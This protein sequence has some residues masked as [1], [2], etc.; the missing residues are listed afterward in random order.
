M[1]KI[2]E[3]IKNF[4]IKIKDIIVDFCVNYFPKG[5]PK[6][7]LFPL[8]LMLLIE[9]I[10]TTMIGA[11]GGYLLVDIG[12]AKDV[13]DAGTY[14]GWLTS[15]FH[16][17]QFLSSFVIGALSDNIG[18]RPMLLFG[19]FG[20]ALTNILFG[21]SFN[22]YYAIAMRFINGLINGNIGV[23]KTYMGEVS[24]PENR[25]KTFS[26]VGLTWA[27]GSVVGNFL[28]GILYDPC[29]K[30][31]SVF[32]TSGLFK[33]FPA[34]L[35]QGSVGIVGFIVLI[36]AYFYLPENI[37][38]GKLDESVKVNKC[39]SILE[40]IKMVFV[41]M[42]RFFNRKNKWSLF[43]TFEYF[44]L[45]FCH[46]TFLT[47]YPLLII[48]SVGNGGFGLTTNEVG[49]FSAIAFTGSIVTLSFFYNPLVRLFGMR[50]TFSITAYITAC[51]YGL[52]PALE[53]LND[54]SDGVKWTC[55]ALLAFGWNLANQCTFSAIM[56]LIVN[57]CEASYMGSANGIAQMVVSLGRILGPILLSPLLSWSLDNGLSYP[58]NQY[59][60][61]YILLV[62]A[63]INASLMFITPERI[64][65]PPVSKT[66]DEEEMQ[67]EIAEEKELLPSENETS[68]LVGNEEK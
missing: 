65:R 35:P 40:S 38:P 43:C 14:T 3:A 45:G 19:T 54:S 31:P 44:L 15:S 42:Y 51:F 63:C 47:L 48:A 5:F 68:S 28:G 58:F 41:K 36:L 50:K 64:E 11:Y 33:Q 18:R 2:L 12:M 62:I 67:T 4:F 46:T 27:V 9:G 1:A 60:P 7:K 59:L 49:Y 26:F 37:V 23:V 32:G 61:F 13:D 52:Y 6:R 16:I 22:F 8:L 20:I 56:T 39:K 17:A 53:G 66:N 21:F 25:V 29:T 57:G 10:S 24:T 34:L 30:Y 55:Y